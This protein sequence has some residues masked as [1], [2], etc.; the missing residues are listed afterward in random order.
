MSLKTKLQTAKEKTVDFLNEYGQDIV[1]V[2]LVA[3]SGILLYLVSNQQKNLL[4]LAKITKFQDDHP[5]YIERVG[6]NDFSALQ[7][8][9]DRTR[10]AP[11]SETK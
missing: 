11:L 8:T 3:T 9:L 4:T 6:E 7:I 2:G 1:N 5:Y 10:K